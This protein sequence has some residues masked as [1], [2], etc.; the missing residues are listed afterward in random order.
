MSLPVARHR[1]AWAT[2]AWCLLP[3]TSRRRAVEVSAHSVRRGCALGGAAPCVAV[4]WFRGASCGAIALAP[5]ASWCMG[6]SPSYSANVVLVA[7]GS[8]G[9]VFVNALSVAGPGDASVVRSKEGFELADWFVELR[10]ACLH[11]R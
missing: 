6:R 8:G 3:A 11:V 4:W 9:Q 10:G 7:R 1:A 2:V 5:S